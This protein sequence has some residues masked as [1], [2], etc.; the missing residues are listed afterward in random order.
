MHSTV[1]NNIFD[2]LNSI[3]ILLIKKQTIMRTLNNNHL[4]GTLSGTKSSKWNSKR[5]YR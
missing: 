5:R 2:R 4:S 1:T 3:N